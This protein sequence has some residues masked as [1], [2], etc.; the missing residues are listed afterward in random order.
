VGLGANVADA[1]RQA[2]LGPL[3]R[4]ALA[5]LI[6]AEHQRPIRRVQVQADDIPKLDLEVLVARQ[7]EGSRHVRL[8]FIGR[9]YPSHGLWRDPELPCHAPSAPPGLIRW[10]LHRQRDQLL[11]LGFRY[12]RLAAPPRRI[13]QPRQ[14][15]TG[16]PVLP[17]HHHRAVHAHLRRRIGLT[18]AVRSQQDDPRSPYHPLR[19]GRRVRNAFQFHMLWRTHFER[20]DRS[21]HNVGRMVD[22]SC[23]V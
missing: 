7:L 8:D 14:P 4:L 18:A 20:L 22:K 23:I 5:L 10:R 13:F 15:E 2:G 17:M 1:K 19:R 12:P 6:A 16:K 3:Q 21:S 9:P 11:P